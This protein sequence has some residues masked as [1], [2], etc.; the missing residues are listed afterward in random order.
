MNNRYICK[1]K[2]KNN[3]EWVKGYLYIIKYE[4]IGNIH[5]GDLLEVQR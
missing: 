4:V 2:P 5:Y 3:G 1:G